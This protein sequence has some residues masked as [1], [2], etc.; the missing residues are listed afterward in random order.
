MKSLT[1]LALIAYASATFAA[2]IPV[3]EEAK[4]DLLFRERAWGKRDK[5][6]ADTL[7]VMFHGLN[8]RPYWLFA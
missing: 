6:I 8:L 3:A 2:A 5:V 7:Y 4:A 1:I